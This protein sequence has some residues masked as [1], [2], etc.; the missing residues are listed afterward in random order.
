MGVAFYFSHQG[1]FAE[2]VQ[3]TMRERA[4]KVDKIWIVGDVGRQIVNPLGATAMCE[5]SALDGIGSALGQ[6]I[7]LENGRVKERTFAEHPFLRMSQA[8]KVQVDFLLSDNNPTGLGEPAL[9]PAIP[10]LCNAIFAASGMR[11]RSLPID[12]AALGA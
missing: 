1:Y 11:I 3:V 4:L 10:A 7:T 9:P 8:P 5:G 2:V 12:L 6:K